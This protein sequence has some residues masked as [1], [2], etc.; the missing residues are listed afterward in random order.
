MKI[1]AENVRQKLNV[2]CYYPPNHSVTLIE[3]MEDGKKS[4]IDIKVCKSIVYNQKTANKNEEI[5]IDKK[6]NESVQECF[7]LT[8][9]NTKSNDLEVYVK[10]ENDL[11]N[12]ISKLEIEIDLNF[13]FD[14]DQ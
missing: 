10:P 6:L 8:Q 11:K 9:H 13:E 1:L 3:T 5:K 7:I 12:I 14:Q 2:P 4:L